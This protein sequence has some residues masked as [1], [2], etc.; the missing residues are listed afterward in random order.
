M[1]FSVNQVVKIIQNDWNIGGEVICDGSDDDIDYDTDDEELNSE[2]MHG[3]DEIECM[4][5]GFA[6]V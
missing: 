2:P 5:T 3:S 4:E 1:N 6:E